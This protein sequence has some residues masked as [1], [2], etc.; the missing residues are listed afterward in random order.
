MRK[1]LLTIL[2]SLFVFA[3]LPAFAANTATLTWTAPTTYSDGT[4]IPSGVVITY[5]VYQGT[6][7]T[8]LTQ[9]I[10]GVSALT[11]SSTGLNSGTTYFFAV[12][13]VANGLESAKS[14]TGSK[15]FAVTVPPGAPVLTVN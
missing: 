9:L 14:N 11:Y 7:A 5:N 4:T 2:S 3:A 6:S 10:S 13:A 15:T 1:F 8:T 12:T